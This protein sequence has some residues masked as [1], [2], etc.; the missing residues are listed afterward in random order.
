MK[1][2]ALLTA[3]L[4][5]AATPAF[6][7]DPCQSAKD[8]V[9]AA[10]SFYGDNPELTNI[11]AP[12][13]DISI[14]GI[15]GNPDPSG[16]LYRFEGEEEILPIIDGKVIGIEKAADWSKKGERCRMIGGSIAPVTEDAAAEANVNFR[17]NY[18]RMDGVFSVDELKEGAK[19]GSKIMKSLA[20]GGLGFVVPGLKTVALGPAEGSEIKPTHKF[21]RKGAPVSVKSSPIG[22]ATLFRLKDIKSAK[23]DMLM[24]EGLYSL[25]PTFKIDPEEI[26][27]QEAKRVAEAETT[28]N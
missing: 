14:S 16:I 17:F 6:A 21:L 13:I 2:K 22:N 12:V 10:Q 24:I 9:N 20:P 27:E 1:N 25:S 4:C 3:V 28:G 15:N 11:I 19:D 26:A 18:K 5:A 7:Y 23:A 8:L